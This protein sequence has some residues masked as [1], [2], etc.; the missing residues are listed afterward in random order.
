MNGYEKLAIDAAIELNARFI[1]LNEAFKLCE[2]ALADLKEQLRQIAIY[3]SG[4]VVNEKEFSN[5]AHTIAMKGIEADKPE[6]AGRAILRKNSA[7][8]LLMRYKCDNFSWELREL[9]N[10]RK[11]AGYEMEELMILAKDE[12]GELLK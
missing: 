6:K 3:K 10:R 8:L 7:S 1:D 4:A 2:A 11:S 9:D 12:F 5:L